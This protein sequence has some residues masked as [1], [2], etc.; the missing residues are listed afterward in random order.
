MASKNRIYKSKVNDSL[1]ALY[2]K[3][4]YL[5]Y[6]CSPLLISRKTSLYFI[7]IEQIIFVLSISFRI[8]LLKN[9]AKKLIKPNQSLKV[10]EFNFSVWNESISCKLWMRNFLLSDRKIITINSNI[11][12]RIWYLIITLLIRYNLLI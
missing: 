8:M 5:C 12:I 6:Y 9:N 4:I 7:Y 3:F 2:T 10:D 11:N 1:F